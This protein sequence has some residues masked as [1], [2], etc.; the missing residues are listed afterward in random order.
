MYNVHTYTIILL[1]NVH[2]YNNII[3]H[4]CQLDHSHRAQVHQR[5]LGSHHLH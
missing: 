4:V 1:I 2:T 3:I 5:C